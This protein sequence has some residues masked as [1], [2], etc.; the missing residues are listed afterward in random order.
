MSLQRLP[1]HVSLDDAGFR[2]RSSGPA[3]RAFV[4]TV[5]FL[6][7][8]NQEASQLLG[9]L[10]ETTYERWCVRWRPI[11]PEPPSSEFP[12]SECTDRDR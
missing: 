6:R 5:R 3:F 8:S 2:R 9:D 12:T 10:P 7:L 4:N 1:T 11:W